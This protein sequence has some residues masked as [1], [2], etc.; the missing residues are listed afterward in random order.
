MGWADRDWGANDWGNKGVIVRKC[1]GQ[2]W[3]SGPRELGVSMGLGMCI[4]GDHP[5]HGAEY[6]AFSACLYCYE[7]FGSV[8]HS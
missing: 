6:L 4:V 8:W 1:V 5:R 7:W 3:W 2:V